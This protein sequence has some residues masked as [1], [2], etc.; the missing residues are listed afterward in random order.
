MAQTVSATK[1]LFKRMFQRILWILLLVG[2]LG[3]G[4]YY[5]VRTYTLSDG[6]RSGVLF[7]ISRKG[8]LFKTYEGQLHL[9]GSIQM[10][11]QSVWNFSAESA[12][13]YEKLQQFEGKN[14]TV[15][16]KEVVNSFPWQGETN[17]LVDDVQLVQ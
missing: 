13:V 4:V 5:L 10:T 2:I 14:V 12:A 16:Y 1:S 17:Y 11:D 7:K 6:N 8:I 15:H 3:G 9:G